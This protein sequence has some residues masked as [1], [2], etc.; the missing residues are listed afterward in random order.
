FL[1]RSIYTCVHGNCQYFYFKRTATYHTM[2]RDFHFINWCYLGCAR[3]P[4]IS[5]NWYY[6]EYWRFYYAWCGFFLVILFDF[7]KKI[8]AL[9]S[10]LCN[11]I[12]YV[13]YFYY[14]VVTI[15]RG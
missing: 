7:S 4:A 2:G 3:W 11:Y 15:C 1:S 10:C 5:I 6:L 8:H 9:F 14:L 13:G 12:C